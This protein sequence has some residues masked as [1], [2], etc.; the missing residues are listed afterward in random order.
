[1]SESLTGLSTLYAASP[2][3]TQFFCIHFQGSSKCLC[4]RHLMLRILVLLSTPNGPPGQ[5]ICPS[6]WSRCLLLLVCLSGSPHPQAKQKAAAQ[7]V[8]VLQSRLAG[9]KL[10]NAAINPVAGASA[11]TSRMHQC[12]LHAA[13]SMRAATAAVLKFTCCNTQACVGSTCS[14][15]QQPNAHTSCRYCAELH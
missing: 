5:N 4:C 9:D 7:C 3:M 13:A 15:I 1:M 10:C 11:T 2:D 8:Q 12:K 6:G 14:S